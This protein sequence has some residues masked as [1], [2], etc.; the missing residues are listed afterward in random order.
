MILQGGIAAIRE[1]NAREADPDHNTREADPDHNVWEAYRDWLSHLPTVVDPELSFAPDACWLIAIRNWRVAAVL[2]CD[3]DKLR[4]MPH[5]AI[6]NR[7]DAVNWVAK[8]RDRPGTRL[9]KTQDQMLAALTRGDNKADT[10][11]S[12][13]AVLSPPWPP[14]K[15]KVHKVRESR[16][17]RYRTSRDRAEVGWQ[18]TRP[19]MAVSAGRHSTS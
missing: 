3:K 8:L 12:I 6:M 1:H 10:G 7:A 19:T 15:V 14:T 17:W 11:T 13:V 2:P 9:S 16:N 4:D 5:A 18:Q